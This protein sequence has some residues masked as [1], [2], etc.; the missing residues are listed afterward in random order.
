MATKDYIKL[1]RPWQWYKNLLVFIAI[2]FVEI[3]QQWPWE[4]IPAIFDWTNYPLLILGFVAL[5]LVSSAG[6]IINDISDMEKDSVHPEKR[7]RPL[8]SGGA[9]KGMAYILAAILM[10]VGIWLSYYGVGILGAFYR[11]GAVG[12][13]FLLVVILYIV[14]AQLY[15][16]FLRK[17]A[18]VDVVILA[19]G[20]ILR[21]IGG[22]F[23]IGVPFTSWLVVGI[24]F[25]ALILGFGKRKNEL[26]FLG[27]GA[28][29]HKPVF[30]QY[31]ES[32]LDQ[33]IT[34][35]AT[36]F[37][38]FY[39][40]YVYNNFPDPVTQPVMM[41]VPIAAGLILRYVYLIQSGSPVGRKPHLAFK[42]L[43]I[44]VGS[45]IFLVTLIFTMFFWQPIFDFILTIFPPPEALP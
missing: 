24:F 33:G 26:Q 44:L 5:C 6:Y 40:L 4:N 20:F 21:A 10:V 7:N 45:L 12:G 3:P 29:H 2:I 8:P 23:L 34:M 37:V 1:M 13:F 25:F 28:E 38:L 39:T 22:T 11:V 27:E 15:N 9:S 30:N 16:H 32:T 36:W 14:N 18:V 35:S 17:W 19:V 41:T 42:D 31:T 43:G